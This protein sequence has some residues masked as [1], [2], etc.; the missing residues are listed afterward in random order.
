MRL[1][2]V[3]D[4]E[5]GKADSYAVQFGVPA[6]SD[7]R[8]MFEAVPDIDIVAI[9]T[10]SGMHFEHAMEIMTRFGKNV[11]IEKPTF[12]LPNQLEQAYETAKEHGL[13]IF[14]V[15]Q[16]RYNKAVRRVQQALETGELGEIR[17]VSVRLRVVQAAALLRYGT[18]ARNVLP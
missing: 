2:A 3:C 13:M 4:L 16:N 11:I 1:A 7:Y 12:M 6:F 18:M 8:K 15:F 14:P 17:T 9:V 10:P 5:V